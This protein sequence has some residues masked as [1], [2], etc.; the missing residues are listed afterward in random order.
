VGP[1]ST[2]GGDTMTRVAD[3]VAK[4]AAAKQATQDAKVKRVMSRR[5]DV[6]AHIRDSFQKAAEWDPKKGD[7]QHLRRALRPR[8]RM[9]RRLDFEQVD[10]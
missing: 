7:V 8:L 6:E 10:A 3:D 4:K 2:Y 9:D 5:S 1:E